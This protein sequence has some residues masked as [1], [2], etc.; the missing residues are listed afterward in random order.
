MAI[1]GIPPLSLAATL[2]ALQSVQPVILQDAPQSFAPPV[3]RGP[4]APAYAVPPA[5]TGRQLL[6][7]LDQALFRDL[8]GNAQ[9]GD[10]TSMAPDLM[11][12]V[13]GQLGVPTGIA[14]DLLPPPLQ[15]STAGSM[16][17]STSVASLFEAMQLLGGATGEE[18]G[19]LLDVLA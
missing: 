19:S 12:M 18:R 16:L 3:P 6:A 10:L 17:L 13:T 11:Q 2:P 14:A 8:L 7:S 9:P 5:A 15:A 4:A 1:S